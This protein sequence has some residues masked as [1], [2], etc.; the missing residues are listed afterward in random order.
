M[1][2]SPVFFFTDVILRQSL[3]GMLAADDVNLEHNEFLPVHI[4]SHQTKNNKYE[5]T[6]YRKL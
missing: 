4:M 1:S 3:R 2:I 5:C 6:I